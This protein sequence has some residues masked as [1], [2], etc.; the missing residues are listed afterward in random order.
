[1][2]LVAL[3][4]LPTDVTLVVI[5]DEHLPGFHR[6]AVPVTPAGTAIDNS[7]SLLA[8]AVD[9]DTGVER[10]LENCD[11]VAIADRQPG[12]A[13]HAAL[14]GRP[15]EVDLIGG[16]RQQYLSRAAKVAEA[17][18]DQPD[19][20]LQTHIRI[21]PQTYLT[22]PDIAERHRKAQFTPARLR[23]GGIKHP[24]PEHAQ[25]ELADA[26]LHSQEQAII[27]QTGIV[28]TVV[29]DDAGFDKSA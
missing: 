22:M 3:I 14:I 26:A 8:F 7:G 6:F 21:E 27:G 19:H 1:M 11:D 2:L 15:R 16:H 24:G 17:G 12:E 23:P 20:L 25:L 18:E 4:F 10:V 28:R 9:I 13:G 29:I 5:P